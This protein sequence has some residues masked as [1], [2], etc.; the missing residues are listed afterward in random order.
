LATLGGVQPTDESRIREDIIAHGYTV[1]HDVVPA[2]TVATIR[3]HWLDAFAES[4]DTRPVIWGP[5]L[6]EVN[7]LVWDASPTHAFHRSYD[8][9]WNTPLHAPTRDVGIALSR[10]RNR[11]AELDEREGE[12][13]DPSCYGIY[14]TTSYYPAGSGWMAE[15]EDEVDPGKRH[16]HFILPI[17]FKGEDY[18]SGGLYLTDRNGNR[19]DVDAETRPGSVVFFDGTRPHGVDRIEPLPGKTCGRMQLFAIPVVM[20]MPHRHDRILEDMPLAR[21]VKARLRRVRDRIRGR[22]PV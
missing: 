15:H 10:M 9:L 21:Y 5:Y 22:L 16:W 19:V 18:A 3:D 1:V 2:A 13:L 7:R 6:G 20:E 12:Y 11:I 4:S 17:T 14:I 8:F